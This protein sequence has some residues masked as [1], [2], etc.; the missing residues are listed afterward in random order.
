M[1]S[2]TSLVIP[3]YNGI[4][5]IGDCLQSLRSQTLSP[6]RVIVVDNGSSDG[7]NALVREQFPEVQLIEFPENTGFCGA[8]NEG[9]RASA[10]MDYVILLNNDTIAD[11]DFVRELVKAME[12]DSRRFSAQARMLQMKD[13]S[14]LDDAGDLY[15]ALGWAFAR[16]KGK[17]AERYDRPGKIFFSCAGAAIYRIS[18]LNEIGLFDEHHFAYLEDADIGWRARISGYINYYVPSAVVRHVGS[19]SSGSVYNLFKVKNTSRNSI[20]LIAKN[21]PPLMV[22]LNLPLLLPGFLVKAVFFAL[23]GFGAE[24]IRGIFRGFLLSAKGRRE[25]RCVSF[26]RQNLP[27][28]V[29]IQI[30]LWVNTVRRFLR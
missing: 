4:Q 27:H 24:Y 1:K 9:I 15:C 18:L 28:Y 10:D 5:Y 22:I 13:P 20:Y 14:L 11:P 23:R 21:M 25:G 12:E 19:A 29:R 2:K 30:E 16:G 3:N 8:V 7:S 17:P 26:R 6:D